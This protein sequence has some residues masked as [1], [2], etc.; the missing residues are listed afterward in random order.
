[1]GFTVAENGSELVAVSDDPRLLEVVWQWAGGE[2]VEYGL[3]RHP[4]GVVNVWDYRAG[5][6]RVAFT[7]DGLREYLEGLYAD[8]DEVEAVRAEVAHG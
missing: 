2:Y 7:V 4:V 1:M 8:Q 6:P 3:P 5:A